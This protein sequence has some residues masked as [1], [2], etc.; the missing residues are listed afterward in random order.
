[1]SLGLNESFVKPVVGSQEIYVSTGCE[2]LPHP[3][4]EVFQR[5]SPLSGETYIYIY[6]CVSAPHAFSHR[7]MTVHLSTLQGVCGSWNL[8]ERSMPEG[9]FCISK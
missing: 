4:P 7:N 2:Q 1:M 9:K 5:I 6:A 3:C 8:V